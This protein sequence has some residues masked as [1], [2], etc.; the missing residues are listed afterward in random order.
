VYSTKGQ[1]KQLTTM[2]GVTD[3]LL[4]EAVNHN[5]AVVMQVG[6]WVLNVPL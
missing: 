2:I 1:Q 5:S 3:Q 6:W 4:S